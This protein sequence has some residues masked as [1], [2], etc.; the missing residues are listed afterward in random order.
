MVDGGDKPKL[1]SALL[2]IS[3]LLFITLG[4]MSGIFILMRSP[5]ILERIFGAHPSTMI[6]LFLL[7]P[8]IILFCAIFAFL[9]SVA[10]M[11]AWKPFLNPQEVRQHMMVRKDFE[12]PP[13]IG[14]GLVKLI[15]K[16]H[17]KLAELIYGI[18][19]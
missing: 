8:A 2:L 15:I 17:C 18:K 6:S 19:E 14:S 10:W 12:V 11:L 16:I 13:T 7:L 3:M 1:K 5:H 9:G 4:F